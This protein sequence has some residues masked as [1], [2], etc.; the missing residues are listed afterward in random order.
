MFLKDMSQIE[1]ILGTD[2]KI[3]GKMVK[4]FDIL[5][6]NLENFDILDFRKDFIFW[7]FLDIFLDRFAGF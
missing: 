2:H 3:F 6:S 7:A 1:A 4:I 5:F